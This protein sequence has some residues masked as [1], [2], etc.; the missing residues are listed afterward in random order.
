MRNVSR[1]GVFSGP[2]FPIYEVS[3]R[4]LSECGKI[5]TRKTPYLDTFHAVTVIERFSFMYLEIFLQEFLWSVKLF[6]FLL[7]L[8]FKKLFANLDLF[9]IAL[10]NSLIIK[11][12]FLPR[13]FFYDPIKHRMH[14][15]IIRHL[16]WQKNFIRQ[17]WKGRDLYLLNMQK[18]IFLKIFK[19]AE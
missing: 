7:I 18:A 1:Y 12:A 16:L 19:S 2:Y 8:F 15:V 14:V 4:I 17:L 5:Q 6:W 3:L 9:I 10:W 11:G 13:G